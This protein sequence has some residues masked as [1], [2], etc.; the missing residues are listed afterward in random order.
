M[1]NEQIKIEVTFEDEP[2]EDVRSAFQE[3]GATDLKEVKQKGFTGVELVFLGI[4]LAG[5]VSNLLAKLLRQWKCGIVID[6]R[7][8]KVSIEKNCDLPRGSVLIIHSDGTEVTL[9]EPTDK[10]IQ[11]QI[12]NLAGLKSAG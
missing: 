3:F 12:G 6:T 8:P 5:A 11:N 1:N 10:E 7:H 9:K 2:A 4:I